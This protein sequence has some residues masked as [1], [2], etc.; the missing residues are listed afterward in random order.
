MNLVFNERVYKIPLLRVWIGGAWVNDDPKRD[1]FLW[2]QF[3]IFGK[4]KQIKLLKW[5]ENRNK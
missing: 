2:I 4:T 5:T 3:H 1:R